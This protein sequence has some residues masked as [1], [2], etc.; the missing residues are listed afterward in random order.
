VAAV[1][2]GRIIVFA[3]VVAGITV[4]P[5]VCPWHWPLRLR[6]QYALRSCLTDSAG[7]DGIGFYFFSAEN[8]EDG[9]KVGSAVERLLDGENERK[10]SR[11]SYLRFVSPSV[12]FE[13]FGTDYTALYLSP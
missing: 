7:P 1:V 12:L 11:R 6:W 9:D 4:P 13:D 8:A 2:I 5:L 3:L 10:G